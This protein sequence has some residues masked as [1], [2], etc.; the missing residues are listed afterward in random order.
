MPA[1][2]FVLSSVFKEHLL[3]RGRAL[4][5]GSPKDRNPRWENR[6]VAHLVS[7]ECSASPCGPTDK[8]SG[9]TPNHATRAREFFAFVVRNGVRAIAG[10]PYIG[11]NAGFSAQLARETV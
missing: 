1:L 6:Y 5:A 8:H 11:L 10:C 3:D 9:H 7:A 2:A 4:S